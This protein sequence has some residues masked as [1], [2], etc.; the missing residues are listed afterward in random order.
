MTTDPQA[1]QQTSAEMPLIVVTGVCGFIGSHLAEA[2][3]RCGRAKVLGVD[4]I[5][6]DQD[7]RTAAVLTHL[8]ERPDSNSW[9]P[10]WPTPRSHGRCARRRCTWRLPQTSPH[11]GARD[12]PIRR[13]GY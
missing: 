2:L 3:L 9:R 11:P 7:P 10:T 8:M 1:V 5:K 13:P 12:S 6:P 4:R